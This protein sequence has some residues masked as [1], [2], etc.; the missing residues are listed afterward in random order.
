MNRREFLKKGLERIILSSIPFIFNCGKN[1]IASLTS[2]DGYGALSIK[3]EKYIYV[4][5]QS[6]FSKKV[7]Y[8]HSTLENRSTNIYYSKV[9]DFF[10][11]AS[12]QDLLFIAENSAGYLEKY[13]ELDNLWYEVKNILPP[14]IEGSRFVSIKQFKLYSIHASL[15]IKKDEEEKGIYRFRIDYYDDENLEASTLPYK[16]YSNTFEIE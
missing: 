1:P 9:G 5:Q 3:T 2:N 6:E 7:L 14:L 10:N 15:Y 13:N 12:E 11:S 16:D 4:W 8:I